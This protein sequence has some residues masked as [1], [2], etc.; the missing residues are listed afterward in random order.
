MKYRLFFVVFF[1]TSVAVAKTMAAQPQAKQEQKKPAADS[2][3]KFVTKTAPLP[4]LAPKAK[5]DTT[6]KTYK[7]H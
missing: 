7:K 5:K 1:V 2:G 3:K 4:P 6:A